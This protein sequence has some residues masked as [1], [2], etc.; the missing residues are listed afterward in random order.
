MQGPG[1]SDSVGA[2]AGM[3]ACWLYWQRDALGRVCIVLRWTQAAPAVSLRGPRFSSWP[4][5]ALAELAS[6]TIR[7]QLLVV[8]NNASDSDLCTGS[9]HGAD[10]K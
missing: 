6:E 1:S 4:G 2:A 3:M 10:S 7:G 8:S 5:V 9:K